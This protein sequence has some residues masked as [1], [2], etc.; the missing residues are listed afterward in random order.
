MSS[1]SS[2]IPYKPFKFPP[3]Y[4]LARIHQQASM[5]GK[6]DK[7]NPVV[8]SCCNEKVKVPFKSWWGRSIQKDFHKFG[9]AVVSYFWLLKLYFIS[10]LAIIIIYGAYVHYLSDY[11]CQNMIDQVA[12]KTECSKLFG[13]WIITNEDLYDLI[14]KS[15]D[16]G[17][18][19]RFFTLRSIAF[20]ILLLVNILSLFIVK[21]HKVRY[22]PQISISNFSLLFKNIK[23]DKIDVLLQKIRE[24]VG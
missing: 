7:S 22:P 15:Q 13:F 23:T 6:P 21:W 8:C 11:Y 1:I 16:E 2:D 4:H 9:G 17:R 14:D 24:K 5:P 3:D 20:L 10:A 19:V 18:Q 12:K